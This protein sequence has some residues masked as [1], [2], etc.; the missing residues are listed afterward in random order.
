M[1]LE[2]HIL[3]SRGR[4]PWALPGPLKS[5]TDSAREG[6]RSF[7]RIASRL[8]ESILL[9]AN[10]ASGNGRLASTSLPE[11]KLEGAGRTAMIILGVAAFCCCLPKMGLPTP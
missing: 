1:V 4:R 10:W 3:G 2:S 11:F 5:G 7:G 8:A 9:S 6:R